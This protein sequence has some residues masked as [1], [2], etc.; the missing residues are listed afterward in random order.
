MY[1][2]QIV[3]WT[4]QMKARFDIQALFVDAFK[5]IQRRNTLEFVA[6]DDRVSGALC[7]LARRVDIP[8]IIVHHIKKTDNPVCQIE[9]IRGSGRISDDARQILILQKK[10]RNDNDPEFFLD[11]A[12]NNNGPTGIVR[13]VREAA[14]QRFTEFEEPKYDFQRSPRGVKEES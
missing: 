13:M 8:L 9:D 6:E 5:D 10:V 4:I 11:I 7:N 14:I 12:K 3:A 1:T 2:E